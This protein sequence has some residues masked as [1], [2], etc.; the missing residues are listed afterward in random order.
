MSISDRTID[1]GRRQTVE[2]SATLAATK[3]SRRYR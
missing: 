2:G 1:S 3:N